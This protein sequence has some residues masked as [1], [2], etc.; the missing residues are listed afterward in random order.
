MTADDLHQRH[1]RD[2]AE[3]IL[4]VACRWVVTPEAQRLVDDLV[5]ATS[6]DRAR[7][8]GIMAGAMERALLQVARENERAFLWGNGGP[9]PRG[10]LVALPPLA[11]PRD[12]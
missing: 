4:A 9:P 11:G 3:R 12:L 2:Q 6:L 7:V 8:E 1:E 5:A 10:I